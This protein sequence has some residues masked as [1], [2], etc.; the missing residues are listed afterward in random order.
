MSYLFRSPGTQPGDTIREYVL[1]QVRANALTRRVG[2]P[3]FL[4]ARVPRYVSR[5]HVFKGPCPIYR[6]SVEC[7]LECIRTKISLTPRALRPTVLRHERV[8]AKSGVR[9]VASK[10]GNKNSITRDSSLKLRLYLK[11]QISYR[12]E[13]K[14]TVRYLSG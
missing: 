5:G 4:W 10:Q 7:T 11:T 3:A 8:P 12:I 14:Y 13:Y 2:H 9:A 6:D 1:P